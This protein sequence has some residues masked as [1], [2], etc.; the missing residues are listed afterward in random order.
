MNKILVISIICILCVACT[1]FHLDSKAEKVVTN[2]ETLTLEYLTKDFVP[3]EKEIVAFRKKTSPNYKEV[4]AN[5]KKAVYMT[6]LL[7]ILEGNKTYEEYRDKIEEISYNA[8]KDKLTPQADAQKY[9]NLMLSLVKPVQTDYRVIVVE[10][11]VDDY[12][13]YPSKYIMVDRIELQNLNDENKIIA[14]IELFP[15]EKEME[16]LCQGGVRVLKGLE[17]AKVYGE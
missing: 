15:G 10:E 16:A 13:V 17:E 1:C 14:P 12:H 3:T 7:P 2:K 9:M 5:N 4:I 6:P 8:Y 11:I